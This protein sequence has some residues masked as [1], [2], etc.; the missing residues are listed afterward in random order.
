MPPWHQPPF[1]FFST[2]A[3]RH[4]IGALPVLRS[5]FSPRSP[6]RAL[7]FPRVL[8]HTRLSFPPTLPPGPRFSKEHCPP[9]PQGHRRVR[10]ICPN[11]PF[12]CSSLT[13]DD[14]NTPFP[15]NFP[16]PASPVYVGFCV[17]RHLPD[18]NA[19]S[20]FSSLNPT[21]RSCPSQVMQYESLSPY[22]DVRTPHTTTSVESISCVL[23]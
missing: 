19:I 4:L 9:H 5:N 1:R 13:F 2:I 17:R 6:V 16:F 20:L 3:P 23:F 22:H 12:P 18:L 8:G 21:L 11:T 15:I 14:L 10:P 7:S